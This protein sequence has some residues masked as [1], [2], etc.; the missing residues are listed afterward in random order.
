MTGRVEVLNGWN[1]YSDVLY[2]IYPGMSL[3]QADLYPEEGEDSSPILKKGVEAALRSLKLSKSP[4]V[5]NVPSELVK[6]VVK[7]TVKTL[8]A[9]GRRIWEQKKWS[10]E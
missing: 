8:T 6:M 3:L 10:K 5:D 2:E 7:K 4:G 9:L 1:E